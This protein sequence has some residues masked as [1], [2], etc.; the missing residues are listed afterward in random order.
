MVSQPEY[1]QQSPQDVMTPSEKA[2]K[3]KLTGI[4]SQYS[5]IFKQQFPSYQQYAQSGM[6]N[7]GNRLATG[8]QFEQQA[9][10]LLPKVSVLSDDFKKSLDQRMGV[11]QQ[12]AQTS[13]GDI[14]NPIQ[15]Q[16]NAN[17][18]SRLG[19]MNSSI[20]GDV[21]GKLEKERTN[22]AQ[23][24]ALSIQADR[25]AQEQQQLAN[26]QTALQNLLSGSD[27]YRNL[28]LSGLT[29]STDVGSGLLSAGLGGTT[30]INTNAINMANAINSAN[31]T[32]FM[33]SPWA[34]LTPSGLGT[35]SGSAA[36]GFTSSDKRIKNNIKKIGEYKNINFYEFEYKPEY[37]QPKGIQ[38]G[39][40]A[41]EVEHLGVVKEF[42]GIK[43]V[44]YGQLFKK[45]SEVA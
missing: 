18:Y 32:N 5:D 4:S 9:A 15:R 24:M 43:H 11:L 13:L 27:Y 28:A 7:L 1:Q 36:K 42:K 29:G 17:I 6:Q 16:T 44:H 22:A 41:Q 3:E 30:A 39:V 37:N 12:Q 19:G 10:E 31:Q 35:F 23:N 34:F 25:Q 20:A 26:Q 2:L 45:L 8:Q 14:Y 40:M 33:N 38:I 21:L